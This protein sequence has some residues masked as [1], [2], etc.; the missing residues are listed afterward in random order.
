MSRQISDTAVS[1]P[2][3]RLRPF[4]TRYAGFRASGVPPGTHAGLP[5]SDVDLIVSLSRPIDVVQMP[6][7]TQR[8]SAFTAFVCGLQDAPALVRQS[9]EVFGLHVF[10]KP[11]GVRAILG[12]AS[13]EISSLVVNLSDI[14][15]SRAGELMEMLL[16]A[17]TWR[18]RFAILDR[19]F[20]SKLHPTDPPSEIAWAWR[21]LA[22]AHGTVPVQ[23]LADEI[24]WSRQHFR[25]RFRNAIGVTPKSAARV[26]RFQRA[27]RFI[28][29][30]RPSLAEVAATCG[31]FDQAHMTREWHAL[32]GSSPRTWIANELPFIQDYEIGGCDNEPD[33]I[34]SVPQSYV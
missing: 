15:G 12:V 34:R 33:D 14:W 3:P 9:G 7:A 24:G 23:R 21:R 32:A 6:N 19:A 20:L 16:T 10:I 2:A 17:D 18:Q 28:K 5:S 22:K 8:P 25:D 11:L 31:Y 30:Q 1:S 26:F 4:I 27:C 13:A 29:E